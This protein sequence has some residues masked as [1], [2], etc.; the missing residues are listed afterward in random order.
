M[1]NTCQKSDGRRRT[2]LITGASGGIG[3]EFAIVFARHGFD[4]VIVARN[5]GKLDELAGALTAQYGVKVKTI[6]ADLSDEDSAERIYRE[7]RD[8]GITV[9]QLVN[10]AGAGR[11]AATVDADMDT[12]KGLI[13]LNAVSVTLLCRLFGADMVR[14]GHGRILNVS[15]LGAFIPDPWFNVYGPTKAFELFLT[16]AMYGELIGTGVSVSV[17]CP[18]PVKTDWARNAGKADSRAAKD[19]ADIARAGF[20]GM[21]KGKLIIVPAPLYRLEKAALGLLPTKA[22]IRIIRSWQE[23]LIRRESGK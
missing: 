18:G 8:A 23:K 7:V 15:S 12:L 14:A 9:D 21:Q 1:E 20:E 4:L 6:A 13:H 16:E 22:R 5:A 3:R 2:A 10:N 19:P 11:Q 17:L